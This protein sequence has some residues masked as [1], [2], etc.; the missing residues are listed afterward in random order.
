MNNEN[1]K[2][3]IIRMK[4]NW[5]TC[6]IKSNKDRRNNVKIFTLKNIL[7]I[8]PWRTWMIF[9]KKSKVSIWNSKKVSLSIHLLLHIRYNTLTSKCIS[10][11]FWKISCWWSPIWEWVQCV[12][13]RKLPKWN[14]SL[15]SVVSLTPLQC[16]TF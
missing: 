11:I 8:K 3:N 13:N 9:I 5:D 4:S 7:F 12:L 6:K 16:Y 2:K 10:E 1:Y 15:T 14:V